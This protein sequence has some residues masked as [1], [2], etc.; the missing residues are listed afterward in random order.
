MINR[1]EY[2]TTGQ[3]AKLCSVSKHTLFHYNDV[4]VFIPR[5]IDE[6]G[7]RYYHVLQYDTFCT[8]TQLRTIGMSL[9]EIRKYLKQRSPKND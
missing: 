2:L 8:I 3:F 7:Y 6:N 5:Y 1:K 4:E 9:T